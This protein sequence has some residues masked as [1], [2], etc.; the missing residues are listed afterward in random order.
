MKKNLTLSTSG[1]IVKRLPR[2]NGATALGTQANL[3]PN[4]W[5]SFVDFMVNQWTLSNGNICGANH[6]VQSLAKSLGITVEDIR[7][8]MR[9]RLIGSR[10][11]DKDKQEQLLTGLMGE[12]VSWTIEDR[13]KINSQIEILTR[14]QGG[15]YMPFV[16]AELNKALKMGL[17]SGTAL[18]GVIGKMMGGG[19]ANIFNI[20]QQNNDNSVTNNY[21][22]TSEVLDIITDN[23]KLLDKSEQA[24]LLESKYDL[25]VLP[26][27][28]ATRQEGIDTTKEGLGGHINVT[29][30]NSI[31]DN[32]K[33]ALESADEDHHAMRREIEMRI[34]P[35]EDDPELAI[36]EE[37]EEPKKDFSAFN[38]LNK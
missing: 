19:T 29:E 18:Q 5:E 4:L 26:E 31:T 6:D 36:Y 14:S 9:D 33:G 22:T 12:L 13:M 3:D 37:I 21:V 17:D 25:E 20:F 1:N 38:F 23:S 35:N 10:I 11:F 15:K 24:K 8:R 32:F 30:L 34:D 16:S 7:A 27:V 28:V 2:P